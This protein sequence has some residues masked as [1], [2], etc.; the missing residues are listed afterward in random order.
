MSSN[1][2]PLAPGIHV[3][4]A[5]QRFLGLEVGTRMT[6]LDLD[7]ELL[8]HS[9]I[10]AAPSVLEG[11]GRPRWVLA[12]NLMHHL[13]LGP[14]IAA[15]L[16]AWGAPGLPDK[17]D[18]LSFEGVIEE[19]AHP[20]GPDVQT[21][22]LRSFGLTNEVALLHRP[23]RTLIVSDLVFNISP[24]APWL[25]RAA[26]RCLGGYPGCRVTALERLGMRR[27]L[28]REDLATILGWDFD[29]VVMAHGDV[30]ESG[31]KQAVSDAFRWLG[32][33]SS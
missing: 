27:G 32:V 19:G 30:I 5:G 13:H 9:P 24:T 1:L 17:R 14:W 28:A 33:H 4:D 11:L 26:M 10:A 29:R 16:E 15:G 20:F 7:G 31:G 21:H 6:V 23:S 3:L 12:P 8:V 25:T 22:A 18:D 2:R